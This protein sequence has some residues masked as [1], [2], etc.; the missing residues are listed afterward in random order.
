[1]DAFSSGGS[2][3]PGATDVAACGIHVDDLDGR[4]FR[5]TPDANVNAHRAP[6][7]CS[8]A[9]SSRNK[10]KRSPHADH[11][12]GRLAAASSDGRPI[13]VEASLVAPVGGG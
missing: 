6:P 3:M 5:S 11:H 12:Q 8:S 10:N 13:I 7:T 9:L 4:P 2:R 1:V